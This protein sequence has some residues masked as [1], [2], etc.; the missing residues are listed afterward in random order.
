MFHFP[1][2]FQ[3]GFKRS[4]KLYSGE[5]NYAQSRKVPSIQ[6]I[7]SIHSIHWRM[8][9]VIFDSCTTHWAAQIILGSQPIV[10][11]LCL[12]LKHGLPLKTSLIGC[13]YPCYPTWQTV[14][15]ILN[16]I[17]ESCQ[18]GFLTAKFELSQC[19]QYTYVLLNIGRN[20][21]IIENTVLV[22]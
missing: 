12:A 15:Q 22:P 7:Q 4:S 2:G 14:I 16:G 20:C 9:H 1:V 6:S 3:L 8:L 18:E 11:F 5:L 10:S 21:C 17:W 13:F 19:G